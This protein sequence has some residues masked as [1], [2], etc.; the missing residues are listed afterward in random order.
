VQHP[1]LLTPAPGS[2]EF[3]LATPA[4]T[5]TD[6][7][8]AGISTVTSGTATLTVLRFTAGSASLSGFTE[9][10]P[11]ISGTGGAWH[12]THSV[13]GAATASFSG[14]VTLDATSFSY[15]PSGGPT[16]TFDAAN[17]PP[18]GTLV[19]SGTLPS[20]E[21]TATSL[22]AAAMTAAQLSVSVSAC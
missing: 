5:V 18:L 6:L 20:V 12:L 19:G 13:P 8:F 17:L 21:I 22:T 15:T 16:V 1:R 11:C 4:L 9:S 14:P 2:R 3:T 10:E 7:A